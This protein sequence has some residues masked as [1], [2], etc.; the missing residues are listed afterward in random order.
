MSF[1]DPG[2]VVK[3]AADRSKTQSDTIKLDPLLYD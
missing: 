1:L 2:F 3:Q